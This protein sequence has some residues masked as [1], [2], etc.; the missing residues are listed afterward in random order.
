MISDSAE[1]AQSPRW[2]KRIVRWMEQAENKLPEPKFLRGE[3][4]V[5][6]Q[7]VVRSLLTSLFP[8]AKLKRGTAWTA[9]EVG[10]LIGHKVAYC[11]S[12][13][14]MP[15]T[16][17]VVFKKLDR[18]V[19]ARVRKLAREFIVATE[20]ATQKALCLALEQSYADSVSFFVAFSKALAMKPSDFPRTNTKVYWLL[21]RGWKS[22]Q[23]LR[24]VHELQQ[25]LCRYL[26]PHVVGNVKRI[27]KMCQRLELHFARPGRPREPRATNSGH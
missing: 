7:N 19:V 26:E 1:I 6:V 22:V 24:T 18:K 15:E 14:E 27:E 25:A 23:H 12:W 3:L 8:A 9:E 5:W 16:D 10:A 13:M 11:H 20:D 2:L 4:P 17:S 21:L